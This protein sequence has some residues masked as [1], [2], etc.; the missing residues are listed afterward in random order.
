MEKWAMNNNYAASL[1]DS[2]IS[3]MGKSFLQFCA[4]KNLNYKT[5]PASASL[6]W[7]ALREKGEYGGI[8]VSNA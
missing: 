4:D 6:E 5:A 7:L 1:T 2:V 3:D 8:K